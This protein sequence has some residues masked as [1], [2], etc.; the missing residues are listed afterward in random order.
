MPG[1]NCHSLTDQ[2][3]GKKEKRLSCTLNLDKPFG[4][5]ESQ[6]LYPIGCF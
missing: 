2:V 4:L 3:G 5:W 6:V 1:I